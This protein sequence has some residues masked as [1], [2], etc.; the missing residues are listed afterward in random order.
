[1]I[2]EELRDTPCTTISTATGWNPELALAFPPVMV[3]GGS[4]FT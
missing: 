2:A 4:G 3:T 1:M